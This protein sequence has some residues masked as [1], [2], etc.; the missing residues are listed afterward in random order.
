MSPLAGWR[1]GR[2]SRPD[3]LG[4]APGF[5]YG[6]LS[7]LIDVNNIGDE[8]PSPLLPIDI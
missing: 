6:N 7:L 3:T 8:V 1:A 2:G 5:D 4:T